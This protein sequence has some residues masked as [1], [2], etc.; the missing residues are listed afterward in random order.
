VKLP[1]PEL[2]ARE[3]LAASMNAKPPTDLLLAC[4]MFGNVDI[5]EKELDA[6]GYLLN[7]GAL[8]SEIL[9]R[10]S[11]PWTRKRFTI[12]HEIGHLCLGSDLLGIED[13]RDIYQVEK[14]C[15]RFASELL[16][17]LAWLEADIENLDLP[18]VATKCDELKVKYGVSWNVLF[19]KIADMRSVFVYAVR[20]VDGKVQETMSFK[21]KGAGWSE[22]VRHAQTKFLGTVQQQE[23][24]ADRSG[25]SD[26]SSLAFHRLT[27]RS[28]RA[29]VH[30]IP[31]G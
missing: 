2:I 11:D 1:V 26:S 29:W 5:K 8:G 18:A 6:P 27:S 21:G 14:W 30:L 4:Q 25:N 10:S 23:E 31:S 7:L 19:Q 24:D 3:V 28:G 17:P 15:D 16:I 20:E 12:A 13:P 22:S 9:V